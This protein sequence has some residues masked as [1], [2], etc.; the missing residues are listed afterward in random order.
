MKRGWVGAALF[1]MFSLVACAER[2]EVAM[3]HTAV[4]TPPPTIEPTV[5]ETA[6]NFRLKVPDAQMLIQ[7]RMDPEQIPYSVDNKLNLEPL[8]L[9][10]PDYDDPEQAGRWYRFLEGYFPL[11]ENDLQ[12]YYPKEIPGASAYLF[13]HHELS[14]WP[15]NYLFG[16]SVIDFLNTY[17]HSL[18]V[19]RE[20]VRKLTFD[21]Y[22]YKGKVLLRLIPVQLDSDIE[23]ELLL[24]IEQTD[25]T[26]HERLSASTIV[27][28][29][30]TAQ[31]R[32]E[33]IPSDFDKEYTLGC[34]QVDITHDFNQDQQNELLFYCER[35]AA[36]SA[37]RY[38]MVF[39]WNEA[40]VYR[41]EK[42]KV[43]LGQRGTSRG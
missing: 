14:V 37:I 31:N 5:T 43:C 1:L 11:I 21:L 41:V 33:I 22:W 24:L 30:I 8:Q 42:N 27:P 10:Y 9:F 40:G 15:A 34:R 23:K 6:V 7:L 36:Y 26:V 38:Q 35:M 17:G 4:P 3:E 12:F 25:T 20:E 2:Q 28:V 13:P 16:R 18:N 39:S 32:L 19:D 29:N